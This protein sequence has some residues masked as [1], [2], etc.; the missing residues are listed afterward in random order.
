MPLDRYS[1]NLVSSRQ[2]GELDN[3]G[4]RPDL[5]KL[6][7]VKQMGEELQKRKASVK[8]LPLGKEAMGAKPVWKPK[9]A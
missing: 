6:P 5:Y 8:P 4:L 3:E 9:G 2:D 7:P 1:E